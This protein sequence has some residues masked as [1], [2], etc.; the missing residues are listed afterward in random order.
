MP[1]QSKNSCQKKN[2]QEDPLKSYSLVSALMCLS[3]LI[4]LLKFLGNE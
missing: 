1:I 4:I 3:V 2:K